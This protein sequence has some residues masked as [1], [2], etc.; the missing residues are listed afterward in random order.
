MKAGYLALALLCSAVIWY[1]SGLPSGD[2]D[3]PDLWDKPAHFLEF[4]ILGFLLV[5]GLGVGRGRA[6]LFLAWLL[7]VL[8][9]A[10]D[11]YHQSFVEGRIPSALDVLAD[12]LGAAAGA[13]AGLLAEKGLSPGIFRK[14]AGSREEASPR[15]RA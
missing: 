4:A 14:S 10:V 13:L 3:L 9:G 2:I 15:R 1:F 12:A 8:Y 11:E 5:R 6:Y 7:A